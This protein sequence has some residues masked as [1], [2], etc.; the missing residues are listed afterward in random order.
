MQRADFQGRLDYHAIQSRITLNS[1]DTHKLAG[2]PLTT[3]NLV[4]A[5][6]KQK[7]NSGKKF[8][9]L[10]AVTN[11]PFSATQFLGLENRIMSFLINLNNLDNFSKENTYNFHIHL[12]YGATRLY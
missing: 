1:F 5:E 11:K 8:N 2:K 12:H 9:C 10:Y 7:S 3:G 4:F 6:S